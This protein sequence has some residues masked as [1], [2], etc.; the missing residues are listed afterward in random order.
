MLNIRYCQGITAGGDRCK[1]PPR[2]ESE[3][4]IFHDPEVAEEMAEARK[5][6]GYRRRREGTVARAF[7][8]EGLGTVAQIRRLLEVAAFDT[9]GME[10]SLQRSRTLAYLAQ[11]ATRLHEAGEMEERFTALEAALGSRLG[12]PIEARRR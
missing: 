9:L 3:F 8:F 11:V 1:A 12:G 2:R 10:N 6:G 5:L 7:D 4:C